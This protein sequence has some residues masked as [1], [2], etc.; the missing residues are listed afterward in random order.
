MTDWG[1]AQLRVYDGFGRQ[2]YY[3]EDIVEAQGNR[4]W[5]EIG[6]RT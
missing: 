1:R 5:H 2:I 4:A 6:L 3:S